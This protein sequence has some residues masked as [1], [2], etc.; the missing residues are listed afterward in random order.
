MLQATKNLFGGNLNFITH[1]MIMRQG[2]SMRIIYIA[3]SS[4][5]PRFGGYAS[6]VSYQHMLP[7][8]S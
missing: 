2:T 8:V 1:V 5:K 4:H 3:P 7:K 6:Q